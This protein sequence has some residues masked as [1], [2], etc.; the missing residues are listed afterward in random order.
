M[1][2]A[3]GPRR[4]KSKAEIERLDALL[5]DL[6]RAGRQVAPGALVVNGGEGGMVGIREVIAGKIMGAL[7]AGQ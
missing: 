4:E 1:P 6:A 3:K 7:K 5:D 2:M